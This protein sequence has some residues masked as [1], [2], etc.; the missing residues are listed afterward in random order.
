MVKPTK[1]NGNGKYP[2]PSNNNTKRQIIIAMIPHRTRAPMKVAGLP[3]AGCPGT[4]VEIWYRKSANK[5]TWELSSPP[6]LPVGHAG[7]RRTTRPLRTPATESER[8][9]HREA[10]RARGGLDVHKQTV[11]RPACGCRARREHAGSTYGPVGRG[12]RSSGASA[13]G[14]ESHG[15]TRVALE[16]TGVCQVLHRHGVV[17]AG[18]GVA[19]SRLDARAPISARTWARSSSSSRC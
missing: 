15:V 19:H 4:S 2:G 18:A 6:W 17:V 5:L 9:D 16:S 11:A 13:I 12:R 3:R 7:Q 8:R 14:W 1:V 10:D